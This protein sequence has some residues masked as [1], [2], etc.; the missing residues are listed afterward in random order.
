MVVSGVAEMKVVADLVALT[1]GD[2]VEAVGMWV[3]VVKEREILVEVAMGVVAAEVATMAVQMAE[4]AMAAVVTVMEEL[5]VVAP[6]M[7]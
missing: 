3:V 1:A 6:A 5:V 2:P 4:M 7:D